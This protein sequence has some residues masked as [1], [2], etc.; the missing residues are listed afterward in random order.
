MQI[1]NVE[2]KP[3]STMIKV[4]I[5]CKVKTLLISFFAL[6]FLISSC[7]SSTP[8]KSKVSF[9]IALTPLDKAQADFAVAFLSM[10]EGTSSEKT[11]IITHDNYYRI[12]ELC[13]SG[14]PLVLLPGVNLST[15]SE[16]NRK[17]LLSSEM[18]SL[19]EIRNGTKECPSTPTSLINIIQK[20]SAISSTVEKEGLVLL[21]QAPWKDSHLAPIHRD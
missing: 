8:T 6:S 13:N 9:Y 10:I 16:D 19:S 20:L 17:A 3:R 15:D 12:A 2:R 5:Y 1:L 7:T 18:S 4:P 11:R 14:N 21:A